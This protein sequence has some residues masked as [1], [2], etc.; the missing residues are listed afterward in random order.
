MHPTQ[1][2]PYSITRLLGRGGMGAVYEAVDGGT[3]RRVAVKTLAAHL[4]D[5]PGLRKRFL[6]EIETLKSLR[7]P[8]IVELLAFGEDDGHPYFAMELVGGRSLDQMLRSGRTFTWQETIDVAL[9]I[10]RALKSAHD[11]GVVHRDLKPANLL[12]PDEPAGDAIVKLADFGIARLFGSSGQTMAGMIVGTA[13]YM[14]PE[15]AAGG[16]VDHRVDLY[17]LGLVMFA[18]LTGKP[19]FHGG[20]VADVIRR[21]RSEAAPRVSSRASDVP[22][23]LDELIDRLLAK[24]P[25]KRPASPLAVGRQLAAIAGTSSV[26]PPPSDP[27]ITLGTGGAATDCDLER[28]PTTPGTDR[29]AIPAAA[30]VDLTARTLADGPSDTAGEPAVITGPGSSRIAA[31]TGQTVAVATAVDATTPLPQRVTESAGDIRL[32]PEARSTRF[33]TVEDLERADRLAARARGRRDAALRFLTALTLFGA[34]GA[35]AFWLLRAP[36]ADELYQR[37]Q[38]IDGAASA[39]PDNYDLGDARPSI[40]RFLAEH[41]HDPRLKEVQALDSRLKLNALEK[42]ARKRRDDATM[43]PLEREYRAAMAREAESPSACIAALEAIQ[44]LHASDAAAA[45]PGSS[46]LEA[47]PAF[48]LDLVQRQIDR[49]LPTATRE[50]GEDL[51][52]AEAA[53]AEAAALAAQ[54]DGEADADARSAL[55]KRRRDLLSGIVEIYASRPHVATAVDEARRLLESP[56]S[57]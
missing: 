11:H 48:W 32:A 30:D 56:A 5:D 47:Q 37:I 4:G 54:A 33:T 15:Q 10:T 24:E 53:L 40:D 43:L 21:Q 25:A 38:D 8:C 57:P 45:P 18:M 2:G 3:G 1:L 51:A 7:H 44:L 55:V 52:R 35:A 41:P 28:R 34:V 31:A 46:R 6:G 20:Q 26:A 12:F 14:A 42:R 19:P 22:P 13:E 23:N 16:P 50:R 27:G 49:L 29:P 36:T 39:D 17:A 9:A